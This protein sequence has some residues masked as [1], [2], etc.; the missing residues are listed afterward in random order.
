MKIYP[1]ILIFLAGLA[2][3]SFS[4]ESRSVSPVPRIALALSWVNKEKSDKP[5]ILPVENDSG[6]RSSLLD[7]VVTCARSNP[8][9]DI[10]VGYDS[11]QVSSMAAPATQGVLETY[12]TS[13]IRNVK[14]TDM[15]QLDLVRAYPS[16]FSSRMPI[17]FRVDL[18]RI[19]LAH[20]LLSKGEYDF[21][22]YMDLD[23]G[24]VDCRKLIQENKQQLD[25]YGIL[26]AAGKH[27]HK[28]GYMPY[29]E[30]GFQVMGTKPMFLKALKR[31]IIN[32]CIARAQWIATL[33]KTPETQEPSIYPADMKII[34]SWE[35]F[36]ITYSQDIN[37]IKRDLLGGLDEVV[38]NSY[39]SLFYSLHGMKKH[40]TLDVEDTESILPKIKSVNLFEITWDHVYFF[41]N[42][43]VAAKNVNPGFE[44]IYIDR[45]EQEACLYVP[46]VDVPIPPSRF[47]EK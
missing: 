36:L 10:L 23:T 33:W 45:G 11:D 4:A 1:T 32:P 41:P 18:F 38:Y 24:V 27:L 20:Q 47:L 13:E 35:K 39:W 7:K 5:F 44:H 21:V 3:L 42:L 19:V 40:V 22:V 28:D 46:T 43:A 29:F 25:E 34:E 26:M 6:L 8:S 37:R 15:R 12:P 2:N 9:V 16:S 30:N 17:Y 14:L 31:A